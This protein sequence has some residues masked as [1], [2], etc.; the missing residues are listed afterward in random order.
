MRCSALAA[1]L[2]ALTCCSAQ[3]ARDTRKT[4]RASESARN[5]TISEALV[6]TSFDGTRLTA[7]V[8]MPRDMNNSKALL[9]VII[10]INSWALPEFEYIIPSVEFAAQGYLVL[11]Y[12]ARGW[13]LSGGLVEGAGPEDQQDVST[14]ISYI[15]SQAQWRPDPNNIAMSGISYGGG[16]SLLGAALDSRVKTAVSM[17]AWN[18][19]TGSFFEG[20]SPNQVAFNTLLPSG[21][22]TG[23]LDP[24]IWKI[25]RCVMVGDEPC[26]RDYAHVRSVDAYID[27]LQQRQVPLLISNNF[28]DGL[29]GAHQML[30]FFQ[31][32]TGPKKLLLNQG[33]H[34][35]AEMSGAFGDPWN[36]VWTQARAWFEHHLKGGPPPLEPD[37]VVDAE[38][39]DGHGARE[40]FTAWP[41]E[42]V[43]WEKYCPTPRRW[44]LHGGLERIGDALAPKDVALPE[45]I[46]FGMD[47]GITAGIPVVGE[48]AKIYVDMP[49]MSNLRTASKKSAIWYYVPVEQTKRLC[50]AP[51]V[52]IDITSNSA[53]WQVVAYL[54]SVDWR[55]MGKMMSYGSATCWNCPKATRIT[56]LIHMHALCEDITGGLGLGFNLYSS[57]YGPAN[58]NETL[59]VTFHYS[60]NF[61]VSVPALMKSQPSGQSSIFV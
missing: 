3:W 34:A 22:V 10:F 31:A 40:K 24:Q 32:Y 16:L 6:I 4:A 2:V 37:V 45:S 7:D 43:S 53:S 23:R 28:E 8:H 54:L 11:E 41:H 12:Q 15:L 19:L 33:V 27:K 44:A 9:P 59:E 25:H 61:T 42:R 18:N 50:G 39:R 14:V 20:D 38:V 51:E 36:Y 29:F 55:D 46:S 35:S 21:M 48:A 49:V 60:D 56:R 17:S 30:D 57:L 5:L 58:A 13:W 1:G 52:T 26:F 47:S